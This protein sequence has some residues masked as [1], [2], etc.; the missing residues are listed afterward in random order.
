M[1]NQFEELRIESNSRARLVAS[2]FSQALCPILDD[3]AIFRRSSC[4]GMLNQIGSN[5]QIGRNVL[6]CRDSLFQISTPRFKV[7]DPCF[8]RIAIPTQLCDSKL[9]AP[10]VV[11]IV[12]AIA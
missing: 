5:Q 6:A 7:V 10:A 1:A 4:G 2:V 3:P 8:H 9:S 12:L 11:E